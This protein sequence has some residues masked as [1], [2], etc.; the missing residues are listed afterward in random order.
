[1]KKTIFYFL[2]AFLFNT[3]FVYSQNISGNVIDSESSEPLA[4]VNILVEKPLSNSIDGVQKLIET[5]EKN[6]VAL[7]VGL[8]RRFHTHIKRVKEI[9]ESGGLGKILNA[10]FTVAS[11]IPRWHPY[12]D[13]L[14]LYACR[15]ELGGGVL[16]TEIHEIDLAIWFFGV[17]SS[18]VCV[19]GTY[20]NVGM[21]VEDTVSL[22]LDYVKF[23]V[24][25]KSAPTLAER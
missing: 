1:M 8:Q 17:P 12:E 7:R 23:S 16:L 22:I 4:G 15:K 5:L 18:V 13:F 24:Q 3:L 6:R 11:F 2:I 20:S 21:D 10:N 9:V 14:Q 19:G 25:I